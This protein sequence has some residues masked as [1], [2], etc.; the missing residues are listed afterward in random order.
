MI[1][2]QIYN[3][4]IVLAIDEDK[5]E[6]ILIGRGIAFGADKGDI[7]AHNK[8]EKQFELK[9]EARYKFQQLIQD[10]AID[11]IIA[12]EE[13]ISFIKEKYKK[14]LSDTIYVTLTDHI[15]N[16]VERIRMGVAFDNALLGNIKQLYREEYDIGLE[17][18]AMLRKMFDIKLDKSEANFI[19]LHIINAQLDSNMM[20]IYTI[21]EIIDQILQIMDQRM[22]IV[23][24]DNFA[25]DR[26]ITHCRFFVQRV[27]NH[28]NQK[29]ETSMNEEILMMMQHKYKE[30]YE[31]VCDICDFIK[32]KYSYTVNKDEELYLMIHLVK[33]TT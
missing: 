25:F 16:T 32:R 30:Q 18:V 24:E 29:E 9:G 15:M 1:I 27:L 6:I 13:I 20:Q 12:S 31:C 4:N 21:T 26:F 33:L 11:Y 23:K 19:A 14:N 3:N 2:K 7:V 17:V 28:A 10:T 22:T 5:E 8:I